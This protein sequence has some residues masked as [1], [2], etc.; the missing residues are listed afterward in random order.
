MRTF[1]TREFFFCF[2]QFFWRDRRTETI[3]IFFT[4]DKCVNENERIWCERKIKQPE[5]QSKDKK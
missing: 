5:E 2:F 1:S 4:I 3:R